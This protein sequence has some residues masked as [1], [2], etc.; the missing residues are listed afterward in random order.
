MHRLAGKRFDRGEARGRQRRKDA[1]EQTDRYREA[2]AEHLR[3]GRR[4]PQFV[5]PNRG[6]VA[7][8]QPDRAIVDEFPRVGRDLGMAAAF[9]VADPEARRPARIRRSS[10]RTGLRR[11]RRFPSPLL[12]GESLGPPR[13]Q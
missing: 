12:T 3:L 4:V 10:R 9:P 1:S 7:V 2:D 13:H 11:Q 6:E 8:T 5:D